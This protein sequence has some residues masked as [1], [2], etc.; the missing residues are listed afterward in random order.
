M[1]KLFRKRF[2]SESRNS[3][4]AK[5]CFF[6]QGDLKMVSESSPGGL[7]G[8]SW[9]LLGALGALLGAFGGL[10]GGSWEYLVRSQGALGR[11]LDPPEGV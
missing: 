3:S 9:A 4:L 1:E 2:V 8:R 11:L 5:G 6:E 7:L 10:L